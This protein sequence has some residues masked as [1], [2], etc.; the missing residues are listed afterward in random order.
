VSRPVT[1]DAIAEAI[2]FLAMERCSYVDGA[3]PA[4][5]SR[6]YRWSR[7]RFWRSGQSEVGPTLRG[8]LLRCCLPFTNRRR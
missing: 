8:L 2:V 6:I 7:G 1:A 3:K 5:G 4:F